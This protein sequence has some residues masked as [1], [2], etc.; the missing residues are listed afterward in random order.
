MH[1]VAVAP[2]TMFQA[3][4]DPIR[5]RIARLMVVTGDEIC[6]CELVDSLLEPQYK[7]SRHVKL[8]RQAGMLMAEKDGRWVYHRLVI[9]VPHLEDLYVVIRNLPDS[10]GVYAEDMERFR[11]RMNLREGGRCRVGIQTK[12]LAVKEG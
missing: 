8:L 9:G 12:E 10:Q 2:E 7:L 4:A 5:I 6:L 1:V 3:L 11:H